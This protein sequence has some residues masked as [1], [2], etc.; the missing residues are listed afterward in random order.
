MRKKF[1]TTQFNGYNICTYLW[2]GKVCWVAIQIVKS[3]KYLT[4]SKIIYHC[5]KR[6]C[7]IEGLDYN[8]LTGDTLK[9]FKESANLNNT[10]IR[11][12]PKLIIFYESGLLGFLSY[13]DKPEAM[14]FKSLVRHK[15]LPS[16]LRDGYYVIDDLKKDLP[17]S[18]V[19]SNNTN[20][21]D[22]ASFEEEDSLIPLEPSTPKVNLPL[23]EK[24]IELSD[25]SPNDKINLLL[26]LYQSLGISIGSEKFL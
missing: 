15:I 18:L 19:A 13:C 11:Y 25:S 2:N 5:I 10:D 20:L 16:I 7:F 1:L 4:P 17:T 6:E 23:L 26:N 14:P 3:F 21:N 24:Y 22:S 8:I 9:I 12:A